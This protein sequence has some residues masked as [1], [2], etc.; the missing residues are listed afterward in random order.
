M[1]VWKAKPC[2]ENTSSIVMISQV[3]INAMGPAPT[4]FS[5]IWD[6]KTAFWILHL[7]YILFSIF[8]FR[9]IFKS[10]FTHLSWLTKSFFIIY[11]LPSDNFTWRKLFSSPHCCFPRHLAATKKPQPSLPYL[12]HF[13]TT[14]PDPQISFKTSGLAHTDTLLYGWF[15]S[16]RYW[17]NSQ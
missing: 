13:H 15:C 16:E 10:D 12:F 11:F 5:S 4:V 14:H 9:M 3:T 1:Q 8:S 7:L 6:S 2:N 17:N